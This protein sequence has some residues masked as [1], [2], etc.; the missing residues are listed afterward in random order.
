LRLATKFFLAS[1]LGILALAAVALLSLLAMSHLVAVNRAV[2]GRTAP[3]LRL[4]A[5]LQESTLAL[6]RLER[7]HAL[8]KGSSFK[9]LWQERAAR[10]MDELGALR[11]LLTTDLETRRLQKA[12]ATLAAYQSRFGT[13]AAKGAGERTRRKLARLMDAT[14]SALRRAQRKA[15]ELERRTWNAVAVALPASIVIAIAGTAWLAHRMRRTLRRLSA[16]TA[17]VVEGKFDGAIDVKRRDEIGELA[18]S[19]QTMAAR[20]GEVDRLKEEFFAQ[21]SHEFRTPLTAMR[22]ATNL[23]RDRIPGPLEPKQERLVE[24]IASSADRLLTLVNQI[25]DLSRQHAGL[26]SI[27]RD[28]VDLGRLVTRTLEVLQPQAEVRGLAIGRGGSSSGVVVLGDEERLLQVL[29]NLV[30]NAIKHT[31]SGGSVVVELVS[32]DGEVQ[33]AV[34]DTGDGI[35]AEELPRVFERYWKTRGPRGGTG[36]GLAIVKSIVEAH[37]GRVGAE[38]QVGW[39]SRFTVRL[40]RTGLPA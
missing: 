5:S 9:A 27:Q 37:G 11:G 39:G 3:A 22:E 34:E 33:I 35:P 1:S 29:I 10:M 13:R 4:E 31:P 2:T 7:R 21:I 12:V 17:E 40:P 14:N 19:F 25:L 36:L 24:I 38:S 15:G 32:R 20:L 28:W 6:I 16:A 26:D 18:R 8:L 23:L 30:D